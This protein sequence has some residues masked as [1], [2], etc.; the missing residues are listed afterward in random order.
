MVSR[1]DYIG[2][3]FSLRKSEI[4]PHQIANVETNS[5]ALLSGLRDN[6]YL[7]KVNDAYVVGERYSKTVTRIKNE[8]DKGILKLEVIEPESCP[9]EI[10]EV[11]IDI[12]S[13]YTSV[14][15]AGKLSP[16][17]SKTA[18]PGKDVSN[19]KEIVNELETQGVPPFSGSVRSVPEYMNVSP[20]TSK[21]PVS[22][23]ALKTDSE[24]LRQQQSRPFSMNDLDTIDPKLTVKSYDSTTT[25]LSMGGKS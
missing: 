5:P 6:D 2:Y 9:R 22:S 25:G 19:L 21:R 16:I 1:P 23:S 14:S 15:S 20:G 3:G 18:K 7:L 8:G 12:P 24:L 10:R 4:G 13:G 11:R 17:I